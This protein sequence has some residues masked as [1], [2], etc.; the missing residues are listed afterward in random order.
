[1]R[2]PDVEAKVR[3]YQDVAKANGTVMS[4]SELIGLMPEKGSEAELARVIESSPSLNSKLQVRSGYVVERMAEPEA[5]STLREN[6]RDRSVAMSNM[7]S[8][9]DFASLLHA[10]PFK[11][12]SV[13]GATSYSSAKSKDLDLFCVAPWG[14]L[15]FSLTQGLIMAR[16]FSLL[17]R[18]SPQIC[19]SCVMDEAYARSLFSVPQGPLF[20]RDALMAKVIRGKLVHESLLHQ[21][22]WIS[23][24]YPSHRR[25]LG[26]PK[27]TGLGPRPSASKM[28]LNRFL[29]LTV[30]SF[31]KAKSRLYNKQYISLGQRGSEFTVMSAEDH[32]IYESKRYLELRRM[33]ELAFSDATHPQG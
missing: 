10:N 33:Y 28:L 31:I 20:A 14:G 16:V 19:F 17:R 21:A 25:P 1:M 13:S 6:E 12:V 8:A 2:A 23:R 27:E 18:R 30:G 4:L 32:L 15:W 26:R 11:M 9:I 7:R 29:F 5:G 3:F 22:A 24:F